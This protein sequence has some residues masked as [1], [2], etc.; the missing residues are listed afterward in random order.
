[1]K[2]LKR[3]AIAL[4]ALCV[5]VF[6]VLATWEPHFAS[7]ANPPTGR[8]YSAE[9]IRDDFGVP[10]I[11]GKTD[12]D[13]A[14]GV[15]VAHAED[16]FFTLQDVVAMARGRYG[17]IAG[18]EGAKV[19][20]VYHLIDARGTAEAN[21]PKLPE[22]TRA[23][24]EAYAAGL[25]H[26]AAEHPGEVKLAN[27]FPVA[28]ID[29]AAGFALRQ[30]FFFGLDGVIGPL[31]AGEDL[32]REH[33]PDIPGFPRTP[34]PGAEPAAQATP[35]PKQAR[36]LVLPL[37]EDAEHL[38]S[39]A[40]AVAPQKGGGTTTLISNSH[41][42][43]R[44]GVAWYELVVESGE[45]WHFAG[46][47][48]PGSP[49]PFLGHNEHLGW[50]NTVNT[51]DM[52]DVYQLELD[53]SGTRYR[54]DGAWRDLES[55][56]VTLPVKMGP[57]VLPIRREVLR[58]VHGPV[59]RNDKG[60]FA[61]RYG[62]IGQLEQLDA[63]Y[64]LNKATSFAEW[65]AQISRLA[66]PSTNFIY[67]DK[68]GTIAY[69]YNAAI[70]ARPENVKADWRNV[71]PGDRSELIWQGAVD[72]ETLP[73]IV[74]PASGWLYN[75]NNT[76]FTAAGAG[77]DL[78]PEAFPPIMGIELKQ[79]NRSWRAY[80]LLSEASVLDRATLEAIKY[81]TGY[82]REGYVARLFEGLAAL[83]ATGKLAEARDLLLTWDFNADGKGKAD[84]LAL[85]MIRDFMSA[86]YNNKP[87][88]D[89]AEKLQA[90]ADHL[91][92][93]FG[94]IDPP[95]AELLRLRQG[96]LDLPLDG[97][98]DTL[99][100]STTWDVDDDGR[101]SLKHGDSFI[102]WVEWQ[103]GKRVFSRSIQPFGSASTRPQSRHYT[104]Q[105]LLF[106]E[107]KLKPV[108]FWREDVLA[109]ASKRTTV[110]GTGSSVR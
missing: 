28:G 104:D 44:G 10:H 42:P 49:F 69:V 3:G 37:G 86:D 41:Q 25:N 57:V 65:E 43:L 79:T 94:R 14:F 24:F 39:N 34:L 26:Y 75:S 35:A 71:L 97:G 92:T 38:G 78:D 31:V 82:E 84:A 87:F 98:S 83:K 89:V 58:S 103:P 93:H 105:M 27:L 30:P 18:E 11:Y 53:E 80:K 45:G 74:N 76:P 64:R 47:N 56:W 17:A 107:H 12:A 50:T 85:L 106:V 81:D 55:E 1:M 48:F 19:D 36:N 5:L 51:P 52:I 109:N 2:W 63:Y 61:I 40:F 70:P 66:I 100:A 90:A 46:A 67:A 88:P 21:Y 72:Y 101:L 33:G 9:I 59:I 108:H 23:L 13:A 62:G 77:S 95:M 91:T 54:L 16:D 32:R 6:A 68:T 7:A 20:Y 73:R 8:T 96:G 15:A 99:R 22:D 110:T 60:A 102:Q 29:V 4:V